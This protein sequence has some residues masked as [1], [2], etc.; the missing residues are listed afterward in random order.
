LTAA[1][2]AIEAG[3]TPPNNLV[4]ARETLAILYGCY[5]VARAHAGS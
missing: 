4:D 2:E 5:D 3:V 1:L